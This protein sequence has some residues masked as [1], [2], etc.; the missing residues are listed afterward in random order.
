MP[1]SHFVYTFVHTLPP[2]EQQKAYDANVVPE[3]RQVAAPAKIDFTKARAPLLMIAGEVDRIIPAGLNRTN[4]SKYQA[5]AGVTDFKEFP[6]RTHYIIAQ[7][8]WE[9]VADH[10]AGWI[11]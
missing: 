8:G 10:V 9:E 3:S 7:P 5:S 6:G 2:D 11:G 4:A 1:L